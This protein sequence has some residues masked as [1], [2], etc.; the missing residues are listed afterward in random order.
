MRRY[1]TE[2]HLFS[3]KEWQT[4]RR[5]IDKLAQSEVQFGTQRYHFAQFYRTFINGTYAY[6]FLKRLARLTKIEQEGLKEQAQV[7]R[8]IWNWLRANG[9][10]TERVANAEYLII[11]CMYQW[12]AFARGYIF[13]TAILRDLQQAGIIVA[14]HDPI[15]ERFAPYDVYIPSLGY[16]DIKT[17][18]YFLDDFVADT[19]TADFYITR[20][21]TPKAQEHRRIVFLTAPTWER[22]QSAPTQYQETVGA[23]LA[24]AAS[25]SR[26]ILVRI[27]YLHW[28]VLEYNMWK[29]LVRLIQEESGDHE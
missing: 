10:Q 19:P 7:A 24:A 13:E 9:I 2:S 6:P 4:L 25:L 26:A 5:V 15:S 1:L 23:S 18:G 3:G 14:A 11:Y 21:Y 17:S 28:V 12:G 16:G 29:Q 8:Q 22:L 20:I 27:E